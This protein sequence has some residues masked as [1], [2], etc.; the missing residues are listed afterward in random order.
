LK[1]KAKYLE[2]KA[3]IEG[4]S[5]YIA[6]I[7]DKDIQSKSLVGNTYKEF[8][9][10]TPDVQ[11]DVKINENASQIRNIKYNNKL[12][13]Y[14]LLNNPSLSDLMTD[15]VFNIVYD[16]EEKQK[17]YN[18]ILNEELQRT[19]DEQLVEVLNV[20]VRFLNYA[21]I[22]NYYDSF[23]QNVI[24]RLITHSV[25]SKKTIFTDFI[26]NLNEYDKKYSIKFMTDYLKKVIG[27]DKF[28][29]ILTLSDK[30][31]VNQ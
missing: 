11:L 31:L 27:E 7:N 4:G 1:Y 12:I 19:T 2:L 24:N 26:K 16:D 14:V 23:L 15:F 30:K 5:K 18:L 10:K 28:N 17:K 6:Y 9:S 13:N 8:N 29:K 3:K 20:L 21:Y 22:K 25:S